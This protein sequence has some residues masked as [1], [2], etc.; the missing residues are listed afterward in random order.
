MITPEAAPG[1]GAAEPPVWEPARDLGAPEE[2]APIEIAPA[3]HSK[4]RPGGPARRTS[5]TTA[6]IVVAALVA[7]G[8]VGFAVGHLTG[9]GQTGT[10]AATSALPGKCQRRSRCRCPWRSWRHSHGDGNRRQRLGGLDHHPAGE[11]LD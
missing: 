9:S 2:V 11:R 1:K 6:L 4:T 10:R 8:G 5:S 7:F 3:L